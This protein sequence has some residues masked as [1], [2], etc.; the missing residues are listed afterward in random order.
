MNLNM[1]SLTTIIKDGQLKGEIRS[2]IEALHL[3]IMILGSLRMFVKQ[4]SMADY[5]FDL[6][7][8]GAELI[9]SIKMLLHKQN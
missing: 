9:N 3:A 1:A 4:W 5:K 7:A 8:K 6:I 2:D